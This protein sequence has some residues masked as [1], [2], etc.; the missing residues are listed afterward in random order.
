MQRGFWNNQG[1][2]DDHYSG[3]GFFLCAH[4]GCHERLV[5]L[6]EYKEDVQQFIEI[7]GNVHETPKLMEAKDE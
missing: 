6:P 3:Y 1:R 7:I 5:V 4:N 2:Y